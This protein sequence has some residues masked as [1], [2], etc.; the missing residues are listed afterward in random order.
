VQPNIWRRDFENDIVL[1]NSGN[2]PLTVSLGG[3]YKRILASGSC[4][5]GSGTCAAPQTVA[6]AGNDGASAASWR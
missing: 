6:S 1:A 3:T 5:D 4:P 2:S